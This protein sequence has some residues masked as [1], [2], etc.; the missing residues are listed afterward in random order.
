LRKPLSF[1]INQ[2]TIV[3]QIT[4]K[5]LKLPL[6]IFFL[7]F[8][9][10]SYA[11]TTDGGPNI[12]VIS[13]LLIAAVVVIGIVIQVAENMLRI[14]AKR[15]GI[16]EKENFG[17]YPSVKRMLA[18]KMPDYVNRDPVHVLKK[19]FDILLE[20]EAA[21]KIESAPHVTRHAVQPPNFIGISPIPK[22]TVE[23]GESV[24]AG[25]TIFFD[26]KRPEIKYAAPVSGEII[27]IN[28]G[29]KRSI[30][31][32]I[33]LADKEQQSVNYRLPDLESST[34]E[35]LVEFLLESGAWPLFRQRPYD[36]IPAHD[37]VPADIFIST[38][39]TAPLAPD[40]NFVLNGKGEY[41][42]K[43]LDVLGQL[44]AGAVHL[45]L[46]AKSEEPPHD[47]FLNAD[48]VAKHWF[49]GPHPAGNVGIQIHHT[50]PISQK[51]KVWVLGVQEV[52]SLGRLFAEGIFDMSRIVVLTGSRV[53]DR[54]YVRTYLGANVDELLQNNFEG[55]N[56]RV[57]SGDVLSGK[58][59]PAGGFMN[60]YDEQVTV[61]E[62]GDEFELFGWLFPLT[63]RPSV[64]KTFPNFI[65]PG[66]KLEASTNTHGQKRAFVMTGQY[67][68][69]LPMEIF[70]QHLM[71]AIITGDFE[72]MEGLGIYELSEEDLA[73]CE[74]A[75]TSKMPLQKLLREGLD[76]M[77]EQG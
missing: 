31:E 44:T 11:Q 14:E 71:K 62:E 59:V 32:V 1:L 58:K 29:A 72:K 67:E 60:F 33:I 4:P 34:R 37:E 77:R 52:V 56:N 54:K 7:T 9:L 23:V 70:P 39:D 40:L 15:K 24:K 38:F 35:E 45:G 5:F 46:N 22:V 75:C 26:K 48:G 10:T 25:Q 12:F 49:H 28:R 74:F 8:S 65:F 17:L 16:D 6:V 57:I 66:S 2:V 27:A 20:G 42:Q 47:A 43:G 21:K 64:S 61:I 36:V 41:F 53:K 30:S 55:D 50:A 69:L 63:A 3:D 73:L 13:L 76:T 19:G 68:K 18:P 51:K